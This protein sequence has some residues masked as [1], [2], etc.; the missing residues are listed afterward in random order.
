MAKTKSTTKA[1]PGTPK[2]AGG[3]GDWRTLPR[4]EVQR[5]QLIQ[6]RVTADEA[7]A[8]RANAEAAG[9]SVSDF[10][11]SAGMRKRPAK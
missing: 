6:L 2:S 11:R 5:D 1:K 4:K 10:L 7:A 8:I 3:A 9:Q